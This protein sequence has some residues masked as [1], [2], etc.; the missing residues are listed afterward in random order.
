MIEFTGP[1]DVAGTK[2]LITEPKEGADEQLLY[3]PA[4]DKVQKISGS[5]RKGAFMGSDFSYEDLDL[6][7]RQR[8]GEGRRAPLRAQGGRRRRRRR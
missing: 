8:Q 2:F 3:L 7:G 1:A 6:G 5:S 4:F